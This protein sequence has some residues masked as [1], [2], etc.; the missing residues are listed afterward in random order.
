MSG[1]PTAVKQQPPS[2]PQSIDGEFDLSAVQ[3]H[4]AALE[5]QAVQPQIN[6]IGLAE[7]P[8]DQYG[9]PSDYQIA[10]NHVYYPSQ[11]GFH[12]ANHPA[13]PPITGYDSVMRTRSGR[14]LGSPLTSTNPETSRRSRSPRPK[15]KRPP[16]NAKTN[17]AVTLEEPLSIMTKN[18]AVPLADI[19]AKVH[20]PAEQ[21]Q[22]EVN[23]KKNNGKVPRPM[24]SFMLYRSAY[25]E[26]V[27]EYCKEGNHQVISQITGASWSMEPHEV[28]ELYEKYADID[29]QNHSKAHPDYKF[30]PNKNGPAS[31]KR[32][33]RDDEVDSIDWEDQDYEA[34]SGHSKRTR[35]GQSVESRSHSSTPFEPMRQQNYAAVPVSRYAN[36][37]SYHATNP[38]SMPP[39]YPLDINDQY[40]EQ[41]ATPYTSNVEDVHVRR[42]N[43]P[44]AISYT[45]I[46]DQSLVGLPQG[47]LPSQI[48]PD[49][50][51]GVPQ[52]MHMDPL[53]PRLEHY[54]AQDSYT[55][56]EP[57][58]LAHRLEPQYDYGQDDI[59]GATTYAYSEA[60]RHP[61]MATLTSPRG[62]WDHPLPGSDFDEEIGK[63]P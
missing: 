41:W 38:R 25:A 21:R 20:R 23:N 51:Y 5:Q 60:S 31:R 28:K 49:P 43:Q 40:Y 32:K 17:R 58:D 35:Y 36:P 6:T 62:P 50:G 56:Y 15:A 37:S 42:V 4:I 22:A 14:S 57:V 1:T 19:E 61:G 63:F 33:G 30:A 54:G 16:R 18:W 27:K 9:D 34:S 13:T 8:I 29:R 2:P 26:R 52:P 3:Q 55:Q 10:S 59:F 46:D 47:G 7:Q 39:A 11:P 45:S 48:Q 24:N 12:Q 44:G 53:D